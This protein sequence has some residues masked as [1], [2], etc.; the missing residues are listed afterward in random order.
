MVDYLSPAGLKRKI[1]DLLART[2]QA[3]GRLDGGRA[4]PP[5]ASAGAEGR[6]PATP[7]VYQVR[8]MF[9]KTCNAW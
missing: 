2:E 5:E 1:D 4:Q 6:P 3:L 8:R 7:Q 9:R